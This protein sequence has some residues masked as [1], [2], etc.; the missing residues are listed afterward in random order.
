MSYRVQVAVDCADP[1]RLAHFWA[2]AT[3]YEIEQP[4]DGSASWV[5]YWR[6]RGLPEAELDESVSA[7]SIIDPD[8][9]GPRFWFQKV[10]EPKT[11]KNRLHIDVTVSGGRGVDYAQR[12]ARVEAEAARLVS[13]GATRDYVLDSEP[14]HYSV[15][16]RDP[17]GNE[18]CLN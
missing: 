12:R 11:V 15:T 14:A 13:L 10:P 17:E 8:G 5:E 4:P 3:G 9:S 1:D 18:F 6:K 16:L 7:D 2:A